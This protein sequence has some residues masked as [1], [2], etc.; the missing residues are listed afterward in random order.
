MKEI[1]KYDENK[2]NYLKNYFKGIAAAVVLAALAALFAS[3]SLDATFLQWIAEVRSNRMNDFFTIFTHFGSWRFLVPF[4]IFIILFARRQIYRWPLSVG[5]LAAY[6]FNAGIKWVV[7]RPRPEIHPLVEAGFYSFPSGHTMV[8]AVFVYF[9][10]RLVFNGSI[11]AGIPL[12][13][14]SILMSFSRLY[15]GVHYPSDIFGG[16]A[17]AVVFVL[18]YYAIGR[19][20]LKRLF[21]AKPNDV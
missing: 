20:Y 3:S 19:T 7:A 11:R 8:N 9:V 21:S 5:I 14:Y 13:L 10:Y 12:A 15:L 6:L 2:N 17:A 1:K 4:G 16:Y 18:L